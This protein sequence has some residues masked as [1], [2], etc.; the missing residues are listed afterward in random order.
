MSDEYC[1]HLMDYFRQRETCEWCKHPHEPVMPRTRLCTHCNRIRLKHK[2][3]V[4]YCEQYAQKHGG[5]TYPMDFDLRVTA[6]M[7]ENAKLE[8]RKYGRFFDENFTDTKL[9]YEWRSVSKSASGKDLGQGELKAIDFP[10]GKCLIT[11]W[12]FDEKVPLH[13]D[14]DGSRHREVPFTKCTQDK[15]K[16]I[17]TFEF[18][19]AYTTATVTL[20]P[21]VRTRRR[22]RSAYHL[23]DSHCSHRSF[24][25]LS[26]VHQ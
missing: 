15:S 2:K 1:A 9:E 8:G 26:S 16:T 4:E 7:I 18:K 25:A 23:F 20:F 24:A 19:D 12:A 17:F 5:I 10:S 3:L 14:R 11:F 21:L 13:K 22:H 6:A